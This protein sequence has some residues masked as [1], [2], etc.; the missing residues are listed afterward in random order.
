MNTHTP[1]PW[2]VARTGN[3]QG[4]IVAEGSGANIAVTYDKA[5][6]PLIAAAPELLTT[7]RALGIVLTEL[8]SLGVFDDLFAMHPDKLNRALDALD[9]WDA[10]LAK[11]EGRDQ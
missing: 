10:A 7:S 2:H 6:A 8:T 11:A 3:H 5:D 4:L 1:G 9:E